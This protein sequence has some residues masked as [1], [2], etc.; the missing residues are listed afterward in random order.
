MRYTHIL[1]LIDA[2]L[3]RLQMA[4][5]LLT[6]S[7]AY[8]ESGA[9]RSGSR[10]VVDEILN[11]S[12]HAPALQFAKREPGIRHSRRDK[13][14]AAAVIAGLPV[15]R[16]ELEAAEA[17]SVPDKRDDPGL[18]QPGTKQAAEVRDEKMSARAKHSTPKRRSMKS[19]PEVAVSPTAL[20]GVVPVGPVF[21]P[22]EKI[23]QEKVTRERQQTHG[24]KSSRP[25]EEVPFT[26]ES[27]AQRWLGSRAS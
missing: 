22:V 2:D 23:R 25:A 21:I 20:G 14:A 5:D 15:M 8:R 26:A 16:D 13:L 1:D 27:L 18:Q 9:Q 12:S 4:R 10:T 7:S 24:Q 19:K 11:E 6:T 3:H 17:A